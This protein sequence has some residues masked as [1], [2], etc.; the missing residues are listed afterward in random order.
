MTAPVTARGGALEIRDLHVRFGGVTAV[1]VD[2]IDIPADRIVGIVGANGA[3]KTTLFDAISG[4]VTPSEG[5]I[6]MDGTHDLHRLRP[7]RRAEL[8][9]GRSFQNATLFPTMTVAETIAVAFDRRRPTGG[10]VSSALGA[11]WVRRR[12]RTLR[13]EV[14][15]VVALMGLDAYYDKFISEL[16]TGTRRIVDLGC[17][18]AHRP[19]LLLLDEPSSGIAQSEVGALAELL[20]RVQATLGCT[21]V[22]VEHD[23]PMLRSLA[24][25]MYALGL[26][27]VI[28]HGDPD[29]VLSAPAVVSSYL[30]TSARAVARSGDTGSSEDVTATEN[31]EETP[32]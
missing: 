30:G 13:A 27:R 25:E 22:V 23:I 18:I 11:P 19:R 20:R 1:D 8:G 10:F 15:E 2:A 26:G 5:S 3:G 14:A 31:D 12:E 7:H 9:L 17:V 4:F 21:M 28:A 29:S 24:D 16:S 32:S 6:V